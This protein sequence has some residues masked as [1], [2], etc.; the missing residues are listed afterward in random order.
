MILETLVGLSL[1]VNVSLD[2]STPPANPAAWTQLSVPQ[3]DAALLPLVHRATDC[4]V[5][6]VTADPRY[7][8]QMRPGDINDLI[9]DSISACGRL[10]RTMIDAHDR[11]YGTGSGEA[12]LLGPYLDVLPAAVVRQ[13]TVKTPLR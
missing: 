8:A 3:K 5:R 11:M 2:I 7:S 9:V 1:V 10:V 12:F 6:K 13:V 4:I